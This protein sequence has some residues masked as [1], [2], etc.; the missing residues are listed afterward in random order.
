MQAKLLTPKQ[1]SD[2]KTSLALSALREGLGGRNQGSGF[3]CRCWRA[4]RLQ[5]GS[6][7]LCLRY[8]LEQSSPSP[9]QW[10]AGGKAVQ[11]DTA[12]P[13]SSLHASDLDDRTALR[14]ESR[15]MLQIR[16]GERAVFA[17]KRH[18]LPLGVLSRALPSPRCL[19]T[20]S[21]HHIFFSGIKQFSE[22]MEVLVSDR[23]IVPQFTVWAVWW[24]LDFQKSKVRKKGPVSGGC[25]TPYTGSF[26]FL[27]KPT[28]LRSSKC[29]QQVLPVLITTE[30]PQC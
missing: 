28:A 6:A 8:P 5:P 14:E 18:R 12:P 19:S 16:P 7:L 9:L 30:F 10:W 22:G 11:T 26:H 17:W 20:Y 25:L 13:L 2:W 29:T 27:S 21:L 3:L 4:G 15:F 23:V 24:D 1:T